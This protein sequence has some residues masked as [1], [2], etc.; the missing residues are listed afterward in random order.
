MIDIICMLC[1]S[2]NY[3]LRKATL[4]TA[5]KWLLN[6]YTYTETFNVSNLSQFGDLSLFI[7]IHL[8]HPGFFYNNVTSPSVPKHSQLPLGR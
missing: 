7:S 1:L 8:R 3:L 4:V 6:I 2:Y 5:T